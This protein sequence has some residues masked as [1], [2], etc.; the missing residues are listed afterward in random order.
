MMK[1]KQSRF[2]RTL[3]VFALALASCLALAGVSAA[4]ASALSFQ[5]GEE[6]PEGFSVSG[7]DF[8]VT[9]PGNESKCSGDTT[10]SGSIDSQVGGTATLTFHECKLS[11]V[12][13]H[14]AGAESGTV[15]TEPLAVNLA[16]LPDGNIG[17]VLDPIGTDTFAEMTCS[18]G[19][20]WKW[21]G[22]LIGRVTAPTYE[23]VSETMAVEFQAAQN[24]QQY[25][26]TAHGREAHLLSHLSGGEGENMA[27]G[28]NLNLE[29]EASEFELSEEGNGH[30]DMSLKNGFPSSFSGDTGEVVLETSQTTVTCSEAGSGDG[31]FADST[32]GE[33]NLTFH[34]CRGPFGVRCTTPGQSA[35][36]VKTESLPVRLTYLS[37]AGPGVALSESEGSGKFME[38]QCS[39]LASIKVSGGLLAS[40]DEPELGDK[41]GSF[42][43]AANALEEGGG[44]AQEY[45]ETET[46]EAI[47]LQASVNGGPDE[48]ASI[49]MGLSAHFGV[50][51]GWEPVELRE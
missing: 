34:D 36:T 2:T 17:I 50:V 33:T 27:L 51:P 46:G 31:E 21:S 12:S 3:R 6:F 41:A 20:T 19:T 18:V 25:T 47:G 26:E 13:C 23:E 30:P 16:Q 43:V 1:K 48:P 42:Y 37:G 10:G 9:A 28:G 8:S 45:T 5:P 39:F 15:V 11:N 35:G 44:P 32:S 29:F 40:L 7:Y 14:S 4:G 22:G 49:D 38:M 24:E